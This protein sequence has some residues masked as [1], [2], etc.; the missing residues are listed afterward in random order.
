MNKRILFFDLNLIG[1]ARYPLQ[2]ANK[3]NT[4]DCT[5]QFYFLYEEDPD[6]KIKELNLLIPKNS[7]LIKVKSNSFKSLRN[8]LS[9]LN[10]D[11]LVVSAQR[12]PDSALVATANSLGI[13]TIMLQHGLYIP[14]M[15]KSIAIFIRK[16]FK[17]VRYFQYAIT[18]SKAIHG[19]RINV[20]LTYMKVFIGGKKISNYKLPLDKINACKVL[21]YGEYWKKYHHKE[22]G[23]N[24]SQQITV[25]YPDLIQLDGIKKNPQEDAVCYICQTL[26]EDDRLPRVDMDRFINTLSE[27]IGSKRLYIKLHPR[28]DLTIYKPLL[29]RK[30]IIFLDKEFPHCEK[31]IGHYSSLLAMGMYLTN[32]IFLWKFNEHN[33]YPDYLINNSYKFSCNEQDLNNFLD[34]DNCTEASGRID[35]YFFYDGVDS[36]KKIIKNIL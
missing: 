19:N 20:V 12:I 28:S 1:I 8:L 25:G 13:K 29:S 3:I 24:F 17:T 31:Y 35:E 30:N 9:E 36:I 7:K 2:I 27:N 34:L 26:V 10:L 5:N 6:G 23:Y 15:K 32:K 4:K 22:F 14:F 33:D 16:I 11:V 21:V 18:I